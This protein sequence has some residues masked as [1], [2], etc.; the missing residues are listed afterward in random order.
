[1]KILFLCLL[2]VVPVFAANHYVLDGGSGDGSA[3]NNAWDVLPGTLTRGD[4]YYV[5]DGT[6]ALYNCDTTEDGTNIITIKKAIESDHGTET[7]WSSAYG[8]GS[9]VWGEIIFSTDYWVLDGQVRDAD[10]LAGYGFTFQGGNKVINLSWNS[11]PADNVT[12]RYVSITGTGPDDAAGS[13]DGIY[14]INSQ[15]NVYLG[16][17][18]IS[19]VGRVQILAR[20]LKNFICEYNYIDRNENYTGQHSEA[21]SLFSGTVSNCVFRY[22]KWVDI[23]G[24][25][26]IVVGD[27]IDCKFYG[28]V[29][30]WTT[31]Y[32]YAGQQGSYVGNGSITCWTDNT[33]TNASIY[34]NTLIIP[35]TGGV[36]Y[37]L[38]DVGG[39]ATNNVATNNLIFCSGT[40][41]S[42]FGYTST[43]AHDYN[44]YSGGNSESEANEQT[45]ITS[46]IF[47]DVDTY[48]FTLVSGTDAGI[49]L[50]AEFATDLLGITRSIDG[51][52]DRGAY[53]YGAWPVNPDVPPN[54]LWIG[55]P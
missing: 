8:D 50:G 31:N 1:M 35:E 51:T 44:A 34:N 22:N 16:Y 39:A 27:A 5:G 24:T 17:S 42:R 54:R 43:T 33:L 53:E 11:L 37:R 21:V 3:W 38:G 46:A 20:G 55:V 36:N 23:E 28:N 45:N 10:W 13:N 14:V 29:I 4:T 9:A 41:G 30:Y 6:Y 26:V 18:R 52:W 47:T 2:L 49:T 19:D 40:I 32:P 7:G 15:T 48:D 25:G 12:I